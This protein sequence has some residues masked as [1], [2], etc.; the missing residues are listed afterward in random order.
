MSRAPWDHLVGVFPL[1]NGCGA[2]LAHY[3]VRLCFHCKLEGAQRSS[4]AT[5]WTAVPDA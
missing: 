2:R 1:C 4:T 5:P 3:A